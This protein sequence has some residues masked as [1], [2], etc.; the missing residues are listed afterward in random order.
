MFDEGPIVTQTF[1]MFPLGD[2]DFIFFLLRK[3]HTICKKN[4]EC[5]RDKKGHYLGKSE[6]H[7]QH[8]VGGLV[9]SKYWLEP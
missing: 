9:I 8:F 5:I 6:T 2:C 7:I 1:E 4:T 3:K